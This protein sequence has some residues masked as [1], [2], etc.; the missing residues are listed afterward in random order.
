MEVA[1]GTSTLEVVTADSL[2]PLYN[3]DTRPAP[4]G[5]AGAD[6]AWV[7]SISHCPAPEGVA[8]DDPAQV[9]SANGDPAPAG[10]RARAASCRSM[11]VH[12]GS[13]PHSGGIVV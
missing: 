4:E 1:K 13:P 6:L 10:V 12:E 2:D 11:D 5:V 3:A 7:T 8:G 9:G